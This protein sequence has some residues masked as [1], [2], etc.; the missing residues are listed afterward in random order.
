MRGRDARALGNDLLIPSLRIVES[1]EAEDGDIYYLC[2]MAVADYCGLTEDI[3]LGRLRTD[4]AYDGSR[5]GVGW[6]IRFKVAECGWEDEEYNYWPYHC[7]EILEIP[8]SGDGKGDIPYLAKMC[9]GYPGLLERMKDYDEDDYIRDI[10]PSS[11][12]HD[13]DALLKTY[14]AYF[15]FELQIDRP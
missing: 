9:E 4:P 12:A 10:L 8:P 14:L 5:M 3:R 6:P 1:W 2:R 11:I 7:T 15:G 13:R